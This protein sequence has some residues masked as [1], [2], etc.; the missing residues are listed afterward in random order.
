MTRNFEL[1]LTQKCK[2]SENQYSCMQASPLFMNE[3]FEI[4]RKSL[5]VKAAIQIFFLVLYFIKSFP[6][7]CFLCIKIKLFVLKLFSSLII[8]KWHNMHIIC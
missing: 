6:L 1:S 8:C 2:Q 7:D 5:N 4:Q 3:Y